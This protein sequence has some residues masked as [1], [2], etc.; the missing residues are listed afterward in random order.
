MANLLHPR[1]TSLVHSRPGLAE[2][3]SVLRGFSRTCL[4]SLASLPFALAGCALTTS[5]SQMASVTG[6]ATYRERLALEPE[7]V[8]EATLVDVS[9]PGEKPIVL[10]T[11]RSEPL[12][13]PISFSI[14]YDPSRVSSEGRYVVRARIV[15][16][17]RTLFTSDKD[18][19]VL[20]ASGTKHVEVLLR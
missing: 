19:P 15:V 7:S 1:Q 20:G 9:K 13:P 16:E 5:P 2:Q 10:G 14:R 6:T 11:T 4:A 17:G 8:F 12:K 3:L 18:Y